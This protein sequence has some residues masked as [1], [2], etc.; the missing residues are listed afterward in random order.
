MKNEKLDRRKERTR[1]MLGE[2]LIQLIIE[3][4]YENIIVQDILDRANIG[5]STFYTHF[6]DKDDLLRNG[7]ENLRHALEKEGVGNKNGWEIALHLFQHAQ[8]HYPL[9]KAMAGKESGDLVF[10]QAHKYMSGLLKDYLK[11]RVSIKKGSIPLDIVVNHI[12][13]S[14]LS[15]LTWWLEHN[16]PYPAERMT[17]IFKELIKPGVEK[18]LG[19][20]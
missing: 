2:A 15:L 18:A 4:G 12:V 19:E 9:Y 16:M 13:G 6:L 11:P 3:K 14:F 7:F 5:R 17:E 1:R 20:V 10:K 8:S